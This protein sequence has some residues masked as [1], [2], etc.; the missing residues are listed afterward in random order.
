MAE[1]KNKVASESVENNSENTV[2]NDNSNQENVT[3]NTL[4][5][6]LGEKGFEYYLNNKKK[7]TLY[8]I[9]VG[10]LILGLLAYKLVYVKMLVE[11]KEKEASE[12]LWKAESKAF[13]E[14]NWET[15]IYGDSLGFFKGFQEISEEY[16]GQKAGQIAQ[17][18]LG[19]SFINNREYENAIIAL[20]KVSFKDEL[21]G[22]ITLG[23]IGDSY[24]QLGSVSDAFE[25]YKKAYNRRENDLTS[26]IYLMKA[27]LCHEI[28]ENYEE[29]IILYEM[30]Y[31]NYPNNNNSINAEKYSES[32]KLGSPVFKFKKDTL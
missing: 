12:E 4:E 27:A 8:A 32:L 14:N 23:A 17:Y 6:I 21:L 5:L 1:E 31:K 24:L 20:N 30:V 22:T 19:I 28:E 13:D 18:N 25:Y 7:V 3:E 15:S 2:V 26:P 16:S 11:P 29:A 9:I 10:G